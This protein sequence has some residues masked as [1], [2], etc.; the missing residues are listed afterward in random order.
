MKLFRYIMMLILFLGAFTA[1]ARDHV[2]FDGDTTISLKV[3]GAC[4]MCKQRIE[5]AMK[6]KGVRMAKWDMSSHML[7]VTFD[8]AVLKEEDVHN[9][10]AAIG[11]D[12]ELRKAK[13]DVYN[14]LPECCHYRGMEQEIRVPDPGMN[15]INGVV[16]SEDRK[17][18][19]IPLPGATIS[20]VGKDGGAMTDKHGVFSIP[21]IEAGDMVVS[22][23]GYKADTVRINSTADVQIILASNGT[24]TEVKITARA[25]ST[26]VST[27][28]A[29]RVATITSKELL[30]AA[31]C[32]LSESFETN[33]SVDVSYNDAVTGSKQIQLLGL[34]GIY[35]QLTVENLPG[36]RGLATAL[37]LN[38]IA[39]PWV[40]SIQLSKGTGSVVNGFESIAGQINVELKKPE[41]GDKLYAN[42]YINS[43]GKTDLNLNYAVKL[44]DKWSTAFLLHDDFLYNKTDFNEDGFRDLPTGNQF[45]AVNRWKYDNGNGL[46]LQFGAKMLLDSKTGGEVDYDGDKFNNQIYGLGIETERYEG[47]AKIGYVFP[48]K[49]YRSIGLQL[50]AFS[51]Q[52]DAYFGLDPYNGSQENFYSN[53]I[54]QDIIGTTIHKYRAG[55][56]FSSDN[57]NELYNNMQYKRSEMVPGAFFEYTY[58]MNDKFNVVAG[59]R[60]DHNSL[61][62]WFATPRLNV[63]YEPVRGTTIRLSGGRGQ[64]TANVFAENMG[65]LVS[66][67]MVSIAGTATGKA[68]GLDP[69][70]AWNKGISIDQKLKLFS[71]EAMI[72]VDFFRNDFQNQVV[73][74]MEDPR[75]LK[76]YNLDGRS[77]SNSFQLEFTTIPIKNFDV[78]LAYRWFDVNT[79]YGGTLRQKPFTAAHR[80]FVNL[81]YDVQGWKFD[82]TLNV[83]GEKRLPSTESNPPQY[84]FPLTSSSYVT[85]NAQISKAI[86]K[87]K[88]WELYVGGENLTDFIQQQAIIAADQPFGQYFD[89]SMIWGPVIGRMF[90]GGFR[91]KIK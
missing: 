19:F 46:M 21:F 67:R 20:W 28:N 91:F 17:G 81:A 9:K 31:C 56:S 6:L 70:V 84:Q 59:I 75:Q 47:F 32:N 83:V 13:D 26:Y 45:S 11:H 77:Y 73:V 71:R 35:T 79:T 68:Y 4:V 78:R 3:H 12:T 61:F 43:M 57:Y 1:H 64:R 8:P 15:T 24:L 22:Y 30:K 23:T 25:K 72:S 40:E 39:G 87:D 27:S 36:P 89:A 76:F 33:P 90:Y 7:S 63:R 44:N 5:S 80:A 74:D 14:E 18:N 41:S 86:G 48:G 88:A 66:S 69:E 38:S 85:M 65:S 37:G 50:S 82:Y 10:M 51:H 54:Y 60:A 49:K 55:I 42:G 2:G 53:L 52:Q 62:G 34:S 29:F 58:T 16:M